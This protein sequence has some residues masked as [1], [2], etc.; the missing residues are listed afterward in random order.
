MSSSATAASSSACLASSRAR[1]AASS[2]RRSATSAGEPVD[3]LARSARSSWSAR[4]CV[5]ARGRA[6]LPCL[7]AST[8]G[9]RRR[10]AGSRPSRAAKHRRDDQEQGRRRQDRT[11]SGHRSEASQTPRGQGG[12][13]DRATALADRGRHPLPRLARR[14][15]STSSSPCEASSSICRVV[16]SISKRSCS[17]TSSRRRTRSRS[18]PSATTTWAESA[19]KP[20]VTVQTW[21]SWTERTP[22]SAQIAAPIASTSSPSGA[23]SIRTS[24]GSLIRRQDEARTRAAISRRDDRVDH[25][26]AAGEDEGAGD[27]DAERAERVG[28]RCRSAPSRLMSSRLPPARTTVAARLP[29]RPTTPSSED[30]AALDRGRVPE[31]PDRRHRDHHRDGDQQQAVGQ[32]RQHLGALEAEGAAR[33]RGPGGERRG[34]QGEADR[35]GVGEHVAGVGE[36]RQRAGD[37][38]ADDLDREHRGVDRERDPHPPPAVRP[39]RL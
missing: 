15:V 33:V 29:A 19:P 26:R 37:Q 6:L 10:R 32:R 11:R 18:A 12:P 23:A 38:A 30:A 13:V 9:P 16:W 17:I 20:G 35:A 22:S 24:N 7:R 1:T 36:D 14:R 5:R 39:A 3:L 21:R 2:V 31:P 27:D 25:R 4:P 34:Q 28:G 8:G